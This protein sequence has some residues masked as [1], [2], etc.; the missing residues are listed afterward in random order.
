VRLPVG[1][2]AKAAELV[3]APELL[4]LAR[5]VADPSAEIDLT[6]P[7][8]GHLLPLQLRALFWF[9]PLSEQPQSVPADAWLP[10][11]QVMVAHGGG[12]ALAVKGGHN[13]E[14]H[15]HCDIGQFVVH[16]QT[17]PILIDAG[18]GDYTRTTFSERRYS[19]WWTSGGGHAVPTLDGAVQQPGPQYAARAVRCQQDGE[20]ALIAMDLAACYAEEVGVGSLLRQIVLERRS[21][22]VRLVD[23]V[24][25]GR[26][27]EYRLPLLSPIEPRV[28]AA[29][30]WILGQEPA[31]MRLRLGA[32]LQAKVEEIELDETLRGNWGRLWRLVICGCLASGGEA[33]LSLE[34]L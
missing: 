17:E 10:D 8:V 30:S 11:L 20:R 24:E 25:A 1:V 16:R 32:G 14:N 13:E 26:A 15:N 4:A 19:L 31:R 23:R 34:P 27:V 7:A 21:G 33:T 18:R 29:G 5:L 12:T 2:L 9:D 22:V 6:L 28:E 3:D